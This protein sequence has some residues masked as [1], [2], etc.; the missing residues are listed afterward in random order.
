MSFSDPESVSAEVLAALFD[1]I[2]PPDV[3]RAL[4]GGSAVALDFESIVLE[5]T[6]RIDRFSQASYGKAFIFLTRDERSGLI[7][8]LSRAEKMSFARLAKALAEKY[9]L[10]PEVADALGFGA[11]APFPEGYSVEEG[12]LTLLEPVFLR[13]RIYRDA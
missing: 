1:A 7:N 13:G 4:P 11:R 10:L 9:F 8:G 3:D 12:D 2:I 6:N 5:A